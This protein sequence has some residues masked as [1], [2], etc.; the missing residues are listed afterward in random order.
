MKLIGVLIVA[1]VVLCAIRA[2]VLGLCLLG[3]LLVIWGAIFRPKE[4]FGLLLFGVIANLVA[5]C[6]LASV[7]V[8]GT[9]LVVNAAKLQS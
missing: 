3:A 9:V 1:C 2:L 6:P 5:V 8:I 4:T 7:V